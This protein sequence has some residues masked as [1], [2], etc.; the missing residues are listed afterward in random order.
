[1]IERGSMVATEKD[2]GA[3]AVTARHGDHFCCAFDSPAQQEELVIDFVRA[4]VERGDRVCYF[5]H[6][7]EPQQVLDLLKAAGINVDQ[8]LDRAQL[9]VSTAEGSYLVELPFSPERM[10]ESINQTVDD[11]LADGYNGVHFLGEM[12]WAANGVPG[13][14][15]LEEWERLIED[16]YATR[17]AAWLCQFNRHAFEARRLARLIEL[18]PK[19][20]HL[21]LVSANGLL[22]VMDEGVDDQGAPWLRITGE[23]DLSSVGLLKRALAESRG[24][25]ARVHIDASRLEFMD[26]AG[27][28]HLLGAAA[29][30]HPQGRIVL[31]G[32]R[33]AIRR[34]FEI[35]S[36]HGEAVELVA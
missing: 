18:H 2:R 22:R 33:R 35:L 27:A 26:L 12:E 21:P 20:A 5:A 11:A 4:G 6:T 32:P 9:I 17:P 10:L 31:H 28:R 19:V 8:L 3:P 23:A 16:F 13:A 36:E 15:R 24:S 29:E 25:G 1:M 34:L 7:S 14:E 30:F